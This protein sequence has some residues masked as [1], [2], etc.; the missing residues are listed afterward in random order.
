MAG[1]REAIEQ[2]T[3]EDFRQQTKAQWAAGL[4]D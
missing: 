2:G 3:F 4:P 1:M